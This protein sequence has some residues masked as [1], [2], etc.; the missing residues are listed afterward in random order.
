MRKTQNTCIVRLGRK[1]GTSHIKREFSL[2]L[3][4]FYG[5]QETIGDL[6]KKVSQMQKPTNSNVVPRDHH[7]SD[8]TG[9][10]GHLFNLSIDVTR[11]S[12]DVQQHSRQ[13]DQM[14]G[15]FLKNNF[16]CIKT[17]VIH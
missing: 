1:V 16:F 3:L 15:F 9:V 4:L 2:N 6:Q 12:E 11:L 10:I 13:L 5:K 8:I 7:R 14:V 17:S